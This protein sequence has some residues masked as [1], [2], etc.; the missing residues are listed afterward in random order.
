M[1]GKDKSYR[2]VVRRSVIPPTSNICG[3]DVR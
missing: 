3:G 2:R 1:T